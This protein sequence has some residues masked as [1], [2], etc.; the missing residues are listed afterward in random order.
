MYTNKRYINL[1]SAICWYRLPILKYKYFCVSHEI[2]P[3]YC[4]SEIRK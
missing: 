3:T 4:R 2:K 1:I